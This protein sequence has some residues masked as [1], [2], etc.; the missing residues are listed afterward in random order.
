MQESI[1]YLGHV[2]TVVGLSTD[3]TKVQ[4][5]ADWPT[6]SSVKDLHGFLGL[7]G[8]YQKF[9]RHFSIIAKPLTELLKKDQPFVWTDSQSITFQLLK[10]ALCFGPVHGW[11][12]FFE[13]F[14]IDTDA[15]RSK[16]GA[17]LHQHGHPLAFISKPLSLCNQGLMVYERVFGNIDG[18][19]SMAPSPSRICHPY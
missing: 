12:D 6:P 14:H 15:S 18:S 4:A 11:P 3:P 8:Y 7:A 1:S 19:R 10:D 13:T 17:V 16:I 5:V 2:I 9:V